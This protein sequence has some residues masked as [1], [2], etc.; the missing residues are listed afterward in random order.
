MALTQV[1]GDGLATEGLPAGSVVQVVNTTSVAVATGTTT[2]PLDDTIPQNNE[3]T[4][5]L[6]LAIT[7]TNA[8]NKLKIEVS[9]LWGTSADTNWVILA[10]F[11]DS[12]ANALSAQINF[13]NTA[14]RAV[15]SELTH[16]MT[17]GTTSATTF[18]LR[19]GPN[20]SAT[21]TMNGGGGAR[22]LGGAISSSITITE[23]AV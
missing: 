8:S 9:G 13:I 10:L 19:V 11:Q 4:E 16:F 23:I 3:G 21:I 14:D 7:P 20:A 18:K 17:A 2:I 22:L 5:F 12:T 1:T 6:T 15:G